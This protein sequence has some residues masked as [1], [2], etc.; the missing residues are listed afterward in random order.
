MRYWQLLGAKTTATRSLPDPEN[1]R[2]RSVN[3]FD[4]CIF[5]NQGITQLFEH[6][7]Q[8]LSAWIG[9]NTIY[10]RINMDSKLID[11]AY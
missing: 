11:I 8:F 1:E 6:I 9:K 3:S 2:Q 5:A 10:H 7:T 4:C